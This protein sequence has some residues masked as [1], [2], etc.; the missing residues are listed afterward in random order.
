L[1]EK[2]MAE[3]IKLLRATRAERVARESATATNVG[4]T[5]AANAT[6]L[7]FDTAKGGVYKPSEIAEA[8]KAHQRQVVAAGGKKLSATEAVNFVLRQRGLAVG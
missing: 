1:D 7:G 8:A 4:E 2:R 5:E 3:E 6:A